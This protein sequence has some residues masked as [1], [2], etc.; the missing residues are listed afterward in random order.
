MYILKGYKINSNNLIYLDTNAKRKM[1]VIL[2]YL[3]Q[4][5]INIEHI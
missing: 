4:I 5:I 3:K 2:N 1:H